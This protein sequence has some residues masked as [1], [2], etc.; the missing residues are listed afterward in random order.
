MIEYQ[1]LLIFLVVQTVAAIW[2]AARISAAMEFIKGAILADR[3]DLDILKER[4]RQVE[5]HCAEC[6]K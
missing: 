4:V 6:R 3:Q 5:I 2:W 1:P